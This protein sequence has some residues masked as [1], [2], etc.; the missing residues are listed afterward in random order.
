MFQRLLQCV[1]PGMDL[2]RE[3]TP[4]FHQ[5]LDTLRKMYQD[6][7]KIQWDMAENDVLGKCL[8][9]VEP[10][11]PFV[12]DFQLLK[13]QTM[14]FVYQYQY[15]LTSKPVSSIGPTLLTL[16][17]KKDIH[18]YRSQ[19]YIGNRC[20][21]L[22]LAEA[23]RYVLEH[24]ETALPPLL[25]MYAY[26]KTLPPRDLLDTECIENT[27]AVF[28]HFAIKEVPDVSVSVRFSY[29]PPDTVCLLSHLLDY[30]WEYDESYAWRLVGLFGSSLYYIVWLRVFE[31]IASESAPP[32]L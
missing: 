31:K 21:I 5:D 17:G 12:Y 22:W 2:P 27:D 29:E 32:S 16:F 3:E 23:N 30:L 8:D 14:R 24:K 25:K 10:E 28:L 20:K 18:T 13:S 26:L 7:E 19:S 11:T 6:I 1:Q 4:A 9:Y 15:V